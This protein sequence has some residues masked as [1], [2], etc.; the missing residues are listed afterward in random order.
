[1]IVMLRYKNKVRRFLSRFK[2]PEVRVFGVDP[3]EGHKPLG[4]QKMKLNQPYDIALTQICL[5]GDKP[6]PTAE[7]KY[8]DF[9]SVDRYNKAIEIIQLVGGKEEV[10]TDVSGLGFSPTGQVIKK[11]KQ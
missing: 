5:A 11:Q 3:M 8:I 2:Q 10:K 6:K 7:N 9:D 1:M 4:C